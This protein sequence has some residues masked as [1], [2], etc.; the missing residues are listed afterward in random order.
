MYKLLS[1][2]F[3]LELSE[4]LDFL[5]YS[6]FGK[7]YLQYDCVRIYY[8]IENIRPPCSEFDYGFSFDYCSLPNY[9][10]IN[11]ISSELTE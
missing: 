2:R 4:N 8:S 6:C 3:D 1:P 10:Y 7:S 5:M 11:L 9:T